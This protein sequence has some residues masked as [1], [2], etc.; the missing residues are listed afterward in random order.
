MLLSDNDRF[1]LS[2]VTLDGLDINHRP[3]RCHN[4]DL[5]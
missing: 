1:T 5:L 2:T 4:V 3:R